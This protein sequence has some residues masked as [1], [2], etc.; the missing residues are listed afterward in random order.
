MINLLLIFFLYYIIKIK[1]F[2]LFNHKF[3]K[4]LLNEFKLIKLFRYLDI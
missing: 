1:R 2:L 4:L 3:S